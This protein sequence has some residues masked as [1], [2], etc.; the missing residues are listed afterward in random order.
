MASDSDAIVG[1]AS[2]VVGYSPGSNVDAQW[3]TASHALGPA[4]GNSFDIVS[5]GRG[6]SLTL[7][8]DAPIRNGEGADFAV[9]ENGFGDDF[10]ELGFV[11]VS[12]DGSNYV[13]FPTDSLTASAVDAYETIDTTQIDG[14]AGKYPQGFGV[15]FDLADLAETSATLDVSQITRVRL[16]DVV[17]DGSVLDT[18]G[19][20]IYDPFP[21]TG[22]SGLDVDAVAVLNAVD[23][24]KLVVDF[25][26]VGASLSPNSFYNG[27]DGA[28]GFQA[29][30]LEFNNDYYA[31]YGSWTGWAYSNTTDT[32]TTGFENQYSDFAGGGA[33]GSPTYAVSFYDGSGATAPPRIS[34]PANSQ[35]S[36]DSLQV[37]NTTYAAMSMLNG[38]SFAKR[39]GGQS[40]DDPDFL[41]LTITGKDA[42][43]ASIGEVD[44]YL[45]DYRFADNSLDYIVDQWTTIDLSSIS[46]AAALEFSLDSSDVGAFGIN[47]PTFFAAD[48]LQLTRPSL[49]VELSR[50]VVQEDAASGTVTARITRQGGDQAPPLTVSLD[51][52]DGSL[53]SLPTSV[54]IPAN[55]SFVDVAIGVVDDSLVD[56]DHS[57]AITASADQFVGSTRTLT[58][59][60]NEVRGLSLT[61]AASTV[62]ENAGSE[63]TTATVTRNDNDL[64]SPLTVALS[65]D[66]DDLVGVPD[67][68]VIPAGASSIQF[69]V[70][71]IDNLLAGDDV[72]TMLSASAAGYQAAQAN[73]AIRDD[74]VL[75]LTLTIDPTTLVE[76]A[77]ST[78]TATLSRNAAD[79]SQELTV[80]VTSSDSN[81]AT[82]PSSVTI[83]AG[84][85]SVTFPVTAVDDA[86]IEAAQTIA[87]DVAAE[88]YVAAA[89]SV[90]VADDDATEI[91]LQIS[92]QEFSESAGPDTVGFEDLGVRLPDESFDNGANLAGGFTAGGF[93]FANDY[94]P[95]FDSWTGWALSNTTDTTTPGFMNQYS[96]IPGQGAAGSPTYAVAAAYG[97]LTI[98]RDPAATGDIQSLMVTNTTYGALSMQEGD[99]F[100]KQF[101][102]PTGDD[103]DFFLL[104]IEGR[105]AAGE[106]LGTVDFYLADF[107]FADNS[108]DYI[109]GQWTEVDLSSLAEAS[110]LSFSLSSSDVGDFG[111]NTPASFAIDQLILSPETQPASP[112]TLTIRRTAGN[113]T[114]DLVVQL[115]STDTTEISLPNQVVIPA[116]ENS[117]DVPLRIHNDAVVDGDHTVTITVVAEGANET[118]V[119]A[120]VSDDDQ[121]TL[122]VSILGD[123]L[124][125]D[126]AAEDADLEDIGAA[127]APESFDNQADSD[128]GFRSGTL[129]FSNQYS[130]QYDSWSGFS[131][132]NTSDTET[133]GF[134]NQYSAITGSGAGGSATYAVGSPYS[135]ATIR[136]DA[137]A[138]PFDS[139][140]VTNTTYAALS[141]M[142]GDAFAKQ[143]GGPSGDE[144]DFFLLTIEGRD[145]SG[146]A[147]GTTEFYLADYRF[148]DNSLDYIVDEWTT[149]DLSELSQAT[150]LAFSLSSSDV[151][152]F[153]MNTPAYF[154]VDD[155]QLTDGDASPVTAVVHRND[156]NLDESLMVNLTAQPAGELVLP[157]TVTIPAGQR[158]VSL[159]I[160][161]RDDESLID[162]DQV[163]TVT[164]TAA[165]YQSVTDSLV[166]LDDAA[167]GLVIGETDSGT[168]VGEDAGTDQVQISLSAKPAS[169]VVLNVAVSS[170]DDVAVNTEQLTFT[171]ETWNVPQTVT[172]SGRPD[173]VDETDEVVD[174]LFAVD[175]EFSDA[176]FSAVASAT[177][178]VEM[179]EFSPDALRLRQDGDH[180]HLQADR[181]EHANGPLSVSQYPASGRVEIA[182]DD[183]QQTIV[184]ESLPTATGLVNV[185]LQGGDDTAELLDTRFTSID[186]GDGEDSLVLKLQQAF[187]LS[188]LLANRIVGFERLVLGGPAGA[189][190]TIDATRLDA[191]VHH[192]SL[193]IDIASEQTPTFVGDWV[194]Q[195]PTMVG[196][197][198]AQVI[199]HGE[200][201]LLMTSTRPYQNLRNR[202]DVNQNGEVAS[203]DAL[204]VINRLND[205]GDAELTPPQSVDQFAGAYVDVSGDNRVTALDALRVINALNRQ[206]SS[207][208]DSAG[209]A[210]GE[211]SL[212][213]SGF[214]SSTAHAADGLENRFSTEEDRRDLPQAR[215]HSNQADQNGGS[216]KDNSEVVL[217]TAGVDLEESDTDQLA[218][219][220]SLDPAV[221]DSSLLQLLGE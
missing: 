67:E 163:V 174:V 192:E 127:L 92:S 77:G 145:A 159:T 168:E 179:I 153:G 152:D 61:L 195:P 47:T 218:S 215:I 76:G 118:S 52:V 33:E 109:V 32:T 101:G 219:Q 9:F 74:D 150:T 129:S 82:V 216:R 95:T 125:E 57:V 3:Q 164:A 28:G 206:Q 148:E 55:E 99:A 65:S 37:T 184:I 136:R 183:R 173:L 6:G 5:L 209:Q 16:V 56:G 144:P 178:A 93:Q 35:L 114:D 86:V 161:A 172:L 87:I 214:T 96:A 131:I 186:G 139:L 140:Q 201:T 141:M 44:F 200:L 25:E 112:A 181:P 51:P 193:V 134:G 160:Q 88:G 155:V 203:S 190:V 188:S 117:V 207:P 21:T 54:T 102:G 23:P 133:A 70:A 115:S 180:I 45:A 19:N 142:Q 31:D 84:S 103:P 166:V 205:G 2:R 146:E 30:P 123:Q 197:H 94:N 11:E 90:P 220:H 137:D 43:G 194:Q 107:R 46:D 199:S 135:E 167:A 121:P 221:V 62:D 10:L 38:D 39:F 59:A 53:A 157:E 211:Q 149:I 120:T 73:L 63:A 204:T 177:I 8:F 119:E 81:Q 113:V 191:A 124:S 83:P 210:E 40:G 69:P 68:V 116:G 58:I 13:R 1:W 106:S 196:A 50:S 111:M 22:S 202:Y 151:G 80:A 138:A 176:L 34:L 189:S 182:A 15:P 212:V 187:D 66:R 12:S 48:N 72:G 126:D 143:F 78:A 169:P 162:G 208:G 91:E 26:E 175:P 24:T 128:G 171:P 89:V 110:Q 27:S 79:V 60:D 64:S 7:A 104:S 198:F 213:S 17:G 122:T 108:Q 98:E 36:F 156:G 85:P 14:F 165:A 97:E 217:E 42:S 18:S 29:G 4:E 185:A 100:A 49:Q 147:I 41:L 132:S 170:S 130:D 71:A 20:P 158:T 154:A 105:N 75:T